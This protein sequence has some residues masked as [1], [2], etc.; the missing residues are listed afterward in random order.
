MDTR[1]RGP[2]KPE[3]AQAIV[4]DALTLGALHDREL[5]SELIAALR[6]AD[7]P[8][9]LGLLPM[10]AQQQ[11][12]WQQMRSAI[13]ALPNPISVAQLDDL[14]AEYAAIYLTGAYQASPYE[15]VWTDDEHLMCQ[16]SM[17]TLRK[18]YA[19]AGLMV[20][21]W[22]SRPDDHF[23]FQLL[24]VAHLAQHAAS[25]QDWQAIA[26]FLDQHLLSWYSKFVTLIAQRSQN[27]FY[28]MLNLLTAAWMQSLRAAIAM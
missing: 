15:S 27:Q 3:L 5:T 8:M 22:R 4:D 11:D 19:D 7:F 18:K 24:F 12:C 6:E 23:I 1:V 13:Q 25:K 26:D 16:A 21:N 20:A 17:F 14:A 9:N 28:V 10:D 2:I